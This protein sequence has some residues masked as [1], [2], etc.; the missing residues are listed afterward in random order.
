[1]VPFS[2]KAFLGEP[3]SNAKSYAKE[4][5]PAAQQQS[6][7]QVPSQQSAPF[8]Q[9]LDD[10]LLGATFPLELDLVELQ[11]FWRLPVQYFFNRRLKV[12]FEPPMAVMADEEPFVLD[13]L[14]S[15]QLREQLLH[16][17][18]SDE[19]CTP[20]MVQPLIEGVRSEMRAQGKLPIG[21]FGELEFDTNRVQAEALIEKLTGLSHASLDDLEVDL[22]FTPFGEGK[23]I[24]LSGWLTQHYQSGLLRYRSGKIRSQDYLAGW[25]DHLSMSAMGVAKVTHLIGYDKKEGVVHLKY[26]A[27]ADA[28]QAKSLLNELIRLY[29][30]GMTQPLA[31]FPKTA[32]AAIEAGISRGQWNDDEE[33]ALK[34][35]ADTFNDGFLGAGE[36]A[37]SYISRIWP[38]WNDQLAHQVRLM[39]SLVLQGARLSVVDASE[40]A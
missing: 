25:I 29:I 9:A 7:G 10:Y 8:Y 39:S 27:M 13:G 22:T 38:K 28:G 4:W 31:Y 35:M 34:K 17:L 14:N 40:E 20:D 30:E 1:M 19:N 23:T 3:P 2:P 37:D 11:R 21:A 16:R 6:E 5:I 36:G 33:K 15:F 26:P 18:L 32:L 12:V 24:H